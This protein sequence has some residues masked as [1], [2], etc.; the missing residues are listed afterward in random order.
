MIRGKFRVVSDT[1]M[2][3]LRELQRRISAGSQQVHVGV[4]DGKSEEDGTSLALV[5]TV[6]EFGSSDGTIPERSYLRSALKSRLNQAMFK[7]V[8]VANLLLVLKGVLTISAALEQLG[9]VAA[10][11]VKARMRSGPFKANAPSTIRAKGE[12][13]PPLFDTAQLYQA[14]TWIVMPHARKLLPAVGK[15]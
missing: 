15:P 11:A 4:P 5:A 7:Q 9:A 2:A 12:G 13:K 14:I 3:G 10:A 6:N 8:N 1:R